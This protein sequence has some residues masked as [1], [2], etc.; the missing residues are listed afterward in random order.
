MWM[1]SADHSTELDAVAMLRIV[2]A[3]EQQTLAYRILFWC[4]LTGLEK[5][6]FLTQLKC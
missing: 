5:E 1:N 6:S 3:L 4:D 2:V